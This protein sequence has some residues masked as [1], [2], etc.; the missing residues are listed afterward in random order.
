MRPIFRTRNLE[1]GRIDLGC[2]QVTVRY[3][4]YNERDLSRVP[5]DVLSI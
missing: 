1:S 3:N 5:K 4:H 2:K